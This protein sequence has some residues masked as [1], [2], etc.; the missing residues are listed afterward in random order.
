MPK[1]MPK[2]SE[3][4]LPTSWPM[5]VTLKAVRLMVSARISKGAL[6]SLS[7]ARCTT[8]GPLT[9]TLMTQSASPT[10]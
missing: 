6:G 3:A 1:G 8:P 4:S 7:M 10:P 2:R 9:P 5:R